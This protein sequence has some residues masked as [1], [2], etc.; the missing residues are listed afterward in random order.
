MSTEALI[1]TVKKFDRLAS[2]NLWKV[3]LKH[4][5]SDQAGANLWKDFLIGFAKLM[6]SLP[7][8]YLDL[9]SC[10]YEDGSSRNHTDTSSNN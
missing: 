8:N 7:L 6:V 1:A 3:I 2:L 10:Y 5:D 9:R 4:T